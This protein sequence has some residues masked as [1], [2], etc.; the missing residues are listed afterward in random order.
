MK[1]RS[2]AFAA[3][4][5][6]LF[7]LVACTG[8][9]ADVEETP[10][11]AAAEMSPQTAAAA[12]APEEDTTPARLEDW[13]RFVSEEIYFDPDSYALDAEDLVLL[14]EKA[15]WLKDHPDV[16]VVIQGHSDETGSDEYNFALGDRRAGK[17][18]SYL[19]GMDI[20]PARLTVVSFG[21]EMPVTRTGD[22]SLNRRV[23][24]E[25]DSVQKP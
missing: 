12:P 21:R 10:V 20:D 14:R 15:R 24:F 17:V 13:K 9:T 19:I 25:I 5:V 1:Y 3:A 16:R 11:P 4:V 23:R 8:G 22:K 7:L 2:T 18:K 6:G